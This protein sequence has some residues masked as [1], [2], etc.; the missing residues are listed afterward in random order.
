VKQIFL[1]ALVVITTFFST[2]CAAQ[3]SYQME[4]IDVSVEISGLATRFP[5]FHCDKDICVYRTAQNVG[6]RLFFTEFKKSKVNSV[7]GNLVERVLKS[8]TDIKGTY[9]RFGTETDN[10]KF[11]TVIISVNYFWSVR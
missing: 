7:K 10:N 9:Q 11:P 2:K 5:I 3:V 4:S 1:F 8:A 6:E